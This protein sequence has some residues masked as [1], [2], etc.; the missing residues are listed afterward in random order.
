[1]T[2]ATTLM[3]LIGYPHGTC[4]SYMKD[5]CRCA[6]CREWKRRS[7]QAWK[8]KVR[9]KAR[10]EGLPAH[11]GHGTTYAYWTFFCRC[12]ECREAIRLEAVRYNARKKAEA[13]R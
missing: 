11:V 2:E 7:L 3:A 4:S 1:M 6:E 12:P 13:V 8:D 9:S 5:R 10:N